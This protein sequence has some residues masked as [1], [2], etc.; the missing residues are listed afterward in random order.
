MQKK[1]LVLN[2]I[3]GMTFY[4][5]PSVTLSRDIEHAQQQIIDQKNIGVLLL[6]GGADIHPSI[7]GEPVTYSYVGAHMSDRDERELALLE[8]AL[9]YHVPVFGICRGHQ[10]LAAF[11][12]GKLYQDLYHDAATNH[13][14]YH[15]I[16]PGGVLAHFFD[17]EHTYVN[18]LHHQAVCVVPPDGIEVAVAND[19]INEAIYYPE[20]RAFGVQW[21]P[22]LMGDIQLLEWAVDLMRQ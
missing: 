11:F 17:T 3:G 15:P 16:I 13:D 22:E 10:L 8:T 9:A 18:S 5:V 12:G 14:S 4:G 6:E 19:G 20:N 1:F 21:H 2:S 7:Y